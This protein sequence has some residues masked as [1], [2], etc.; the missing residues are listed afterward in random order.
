[1]T[2]VLFFTSDGTLA[3][4]D[5][6][7]EGALGRAAAS[8]PVDIL[9]RGVP[10][11]EDVNGFRAEVGITASGFRDVVLLTI[12]DVRR[13]AAEL[14]VLGAGDLV[15]MTGAIDER[16]VA[17]TA[18]L[19]ASSVELVEG[20]D[21]WP[22]LDVGAVTAVGA[23]RT[24]PVVNGRVGGLVK[25]LPGGAVREDVEGIDLVDEGTLVVGLLLVVLVN[26]RRG[27][28]VEAFFVAASAAGSSFLGELCDSPTVVV[29]ASS[30]FSVLIASDGR[31]VLII[32]DDDMLPAPKTKS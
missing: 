29:D 1:M 24:F 16:F 11:N 8:P 2:P 32:A 15:D 6:V 18:E 12:V 10:V 9:D 21:R 23:L 25:P 4:E 7:V 17:L 22:E 13:S 5:L 28:A 26:G 3:I 27:G 31:A 30:L 20:C 14:T 19:R